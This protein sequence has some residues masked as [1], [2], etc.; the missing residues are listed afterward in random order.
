MAILRDDDPRVG[1]LALP[2]TAV[3]GFIVFALGLASVG[4]GAGASTVG[5]LVGAAIGS[6]IALMLVRRRSGTTD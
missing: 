5:G 4:V 6:I 2:L 3:A 1:C